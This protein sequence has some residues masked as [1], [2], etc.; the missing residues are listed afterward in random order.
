MEIER[1]VG[2]HGEDCPVAGLWHDG[3]GRGLG[4]WREASCGTGQVG[5]T[6]GVGEAE[7]E[8]NKIETK[9]IW[10]LEVAATD[11]ISHLQKF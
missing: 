4:D 10:V 1:V 9:V 2:G 6:Y 3:W 8:T 5:G 11:K 7:D